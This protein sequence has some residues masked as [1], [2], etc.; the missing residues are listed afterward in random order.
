MDDPT[1]L[2]LI[3]SQLAD[4]RFTSLAAIA[5]EQL[6]PDFRQT[7]HDLNELLLALQRAT[8]TGTDSAPSISPPAS[9]ASRMP[10]T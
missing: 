8:A 5:A 9:T 10:G 2:Y 3:V 4:P 7:A 6:D 1:A